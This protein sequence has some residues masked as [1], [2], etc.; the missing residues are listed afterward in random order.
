MCHSALL[1]R[2][3]WHS[4]LQF[5]E[6]LLSSQRVSLTPSM[7]W[8]HIGQE[9]LSLVCIM[10]AHVQHRHV[11]PH[12]TSTQLG[13]SSKH[14]AHTSPLELETNDADDPIRPARGTLVAGGATLQMVSSA[15]VRVAGI[16]T[17]LGVAGGETLLRVAGGETLLRVASGQTLLRVA[18]GETL[19]Y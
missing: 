11:C 16:A 15:L 1:Y 8:R 10:T 17:L 6:E 2:L 19:I 5:Q 13:V 4:F 9:G 3:R 14:T 18:S 7:L 12:G